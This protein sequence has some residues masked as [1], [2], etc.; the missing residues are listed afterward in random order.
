[1]Q[2]EAEGAAM[3]QRGIL[4]VSCRPFPANGLSAGI[5]PSFV[6]T[7]YLAAQRI[8]IL[9]IVARRGHEN[10]AIPAETQSV[11]CPADPTRKCPAP[12]SDPGHSNGLAQERRLCVFHSSG[13]GVGEINEAFQRIL[14]E[15]RCP[16]SRGLPRAHRIRQPSKKPGRPR[17]ASDPA[18]RSG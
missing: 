3:A 6:E 14:D 2:G 4:R 5:V 18:P 11:R 7:E 8:R 1:M 15:A 10:R 9:R 17:R 12:R 13:F 16:C